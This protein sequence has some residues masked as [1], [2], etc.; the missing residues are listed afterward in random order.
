MFQWWR[1]QAHHTFKFAKTQYHQGRLLVQY[2]PYGSGVQPIEDVLTKIIDISEIDDKGIDI[3]F[4]SVFP[5]KWCQ[6]RD[7]GEIGYYSRNSNPGVIVVSVLNPLIAAPTVADSVTLYAWQRWEQF[8]VA[9]PGSNM[10]IPSKAELPPPDLFTIEESD[11]EMEIESESYDYCGY[12][13]V[14]SLREITGSTLQVGMDEPDVDKSSLTTTMGESVGSL[15]A[16]SRRFTS[17]LSGK[18]PINFPNITWPTIDDARQPVAYTISWLYRFNQGGLRYK[19]IA[20][21]GISYVSSTNN[22]SRKTIGPSSD[23]NGALHVQSM[24]LNPILEFSAPYYNPCELTAVGSK[25]FNDTSKDHFALTIPKYI[26]EN[27][28]AESQ[29]TLMATSDDHSFTYLVGPPVI[30]VGPP[31]KQ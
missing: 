7:W 4:P 12:D 21:Q 2:L 19:V 20:D 17:V 8:E 9:E 1:G 24:A 3:H 14:D 25:T 11:D 15:R 26:A 13:T 30:M 18:F 31:L 28:K 5:Y 27:N 29:V 22:Y 6:V 16:L 23:T 10:R